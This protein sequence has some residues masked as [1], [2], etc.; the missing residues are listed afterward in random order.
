MVDEIPNPLSVQLLGVP[1]GRQLG[2]LRP[3]NTTAASIYSPATGIRTTI[4][5]IF[6]ANTTGSAATYRIFHDDNGTTFDETTALAWN[7]SVASGTFDLVN[8]S[9]SPIFMADDTGNLGVRSGT[10]DAL[11]FTVY[12]EETQ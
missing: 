9:D 11:T 2:Q 6:I 12:G 8:L 1:L 7:K 5:S 10:N 3:S 4:R